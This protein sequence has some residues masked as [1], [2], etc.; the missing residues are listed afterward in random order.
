MSNG[1]QRPA[2]LR[3]TE[4][5]LAMLKRGAEAAC[6][7]GGSLDSQM[8]SA[9]L[10]VAMCD[11]ILDARVAHEASAKPDAPPSSNERAELQRLIDGHTR[12]LRDLQQANDRNCRADEGERFAQRVVDAREALFRWARPAVE[13]TATPIRPITLYGQPD[14]DVGIEHPECYTALNIGGHKAAILIVTKMQDGTPVPPYAQEVID[15]LISNRPVER[16]T[17]LH[18]TD[19]KELLPCE[20]S[21]T[22]GDSEPS[23]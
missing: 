19:D 3:A 17:A 4:H 5:E 9:W 22:A 13:T 14:S 16:A 11:E 6:K 8:I 1:E 7:R 10:V 18:R 2:K 21:Y 23:P 20:S 12:A 15:F